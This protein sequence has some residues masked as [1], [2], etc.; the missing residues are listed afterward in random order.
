[1]ETI[2]SVEVLAG[3]NTFLTYAALFL[4][5]V[6]FGNISAFI[7]FWLAFFG[8]FGP[9]GLIYL[10]ITVFLAGM[11]SDM[12]WYLLGRTLRDTRFGNFLRNKFSR[13]K[14]L[15]DYINEDTLNWIF[16]AKFVSST[17]APFVFL[18]GWA[19][20]S[21]KKFFRVSIFA[22]ANWT[23]LIMVITYLLK[24]TFS[25]IISIAILK[26]L[27]VLLIFGA[28]I[29]L[30]ANYILGRLFRRG[31]GKKWS[32]KAAGFVSKKTKP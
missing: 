25:P 23:I 3:G 16:L 19:K 28:I 24:T 31:V 20:V 15:K 13:I 32:T 10:T 27:E 29:F 2:H 21:F 7:T 1:M 18:T 12:L 17:N 22:I 9:N 4:S 30:V 5:T 8:Y 14:K 6:I 11:F 26:S